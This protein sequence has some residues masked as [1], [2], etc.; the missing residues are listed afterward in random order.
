MTRPLNVG[1]T[2]ELTGSDGV[3]ADGR[4]DRGVAEVGLGSDDAVRDVMF[5]GLWFCSVSRTLRRGKTGRRWLAYA[6]LLLLHVKLSAILEGPVDDISLVA[7][8][9]DEPAG[10]EGG[11]EVAEVLN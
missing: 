5:D 11:P 10:L 2:L 9:L 3:A 4:E 8:A 7:R 1:G 6:V